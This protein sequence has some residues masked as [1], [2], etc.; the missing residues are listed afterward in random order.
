MVRDALERTL[1]HEAI[2]RDQEVV[3]VPDLEREVEHANGVRAGG[4]AR[5]RPDTEEGCVE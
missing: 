5:L 2:S 4:I 3:D 1:G